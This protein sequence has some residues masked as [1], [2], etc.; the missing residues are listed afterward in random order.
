MIACLGVSSSERFTFFLPIAT[1]GA[2][3]VGP[4]PIDKG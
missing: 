4:F 1:G 2:L 3:A